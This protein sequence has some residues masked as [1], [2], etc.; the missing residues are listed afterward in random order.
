MGEVVTAESLELAAV[1]S[2][3]TGLKARQLIAESDGGRVRHLTVGASRNTTRLRRDLS[4]LGPLRRVRYL[5]EEGD[6][7]HEMLTI[8]AAAEVQAVSAQSV[9][10]L[11]FRETMAVANEGTATAL[12]HFTQSLNPIL[13]LATRNGDSLAKALTIVERELTRQ[14]DINAT[15]R[16]QNDDL[17]DTLDEVLQS[18]S[19]LQ[20]LVA[21]NEALKDHSPENEDALR[22]SA[23]KM[24]ND[25]LELVHSSIAKSKTE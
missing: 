2:R 17:R 3:A 21:V 14:T 4:E 16:Q 25:V 19:E 11:T 7:L 9:N 23:T 1:V 12:K 13:G 10:L 18:M 22:E 20:E 6:H 8:A 15:L 24:L 5:T